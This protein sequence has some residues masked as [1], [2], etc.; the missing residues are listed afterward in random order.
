MKELNINQYPMNNFVQRLY[1]LLNHYLIFDSKVFLIYYII[2][3]IFYF[4]LFT[5]SRIQFIALPVLL[6]NPCNVNKAKT[7]RCMQ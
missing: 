4:T 1:S 5:K 7:V 6:L 3:V 2:T